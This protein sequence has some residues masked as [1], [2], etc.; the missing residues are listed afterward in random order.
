MHVQLAILKIVFFCE[1]TYGW[2]PADFPQGWSLKQAF[3]TGALI[4]TVSV[5]LRVILLFEL[6]F[7][8]YF[9]VVTQ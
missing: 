9:I 1:F 5:M 7:Y 6:F 8:Y 4:S 2:Q 3:I